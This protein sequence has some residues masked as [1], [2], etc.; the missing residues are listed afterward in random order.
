MKGR[1][2]HV[3]LHV[4]DIASAVA[5]YR[6]ILGVEPAKQFRDYAKFELADPPVILSVNLGGT[7][8]TVGHLGIRHGATD[9]VVAEFA[10]VNAQGL[11]VLEERNTTCCYAEADKFWVKDADGMPWEIYS[12]TG[13]SDV[14]GA[15]PQDIP[16][17]VAAVCGC[18]PAEPEAP[19]CCA[20]AAR[21][22]RAARSS[23]SAQSQESRW[24]PSP[25]EQA[26]PRDE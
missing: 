6:Q 2:F 1:T 16:G 8:G 20:G 17:G 19:S 23:G 3:S 10:R 18:Q 12:V 14:H 9:A 5:K 4:A 25:G 22:P 7:P 15:A 24:D 21:S 11:E 13:D 26:D